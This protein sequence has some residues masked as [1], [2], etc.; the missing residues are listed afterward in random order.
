MY[1]LNK[2]VQITLALLSIALLVG[3]AF[4]FIQSSSRSNELDIL[5]MV[6][7]DE[8]TV[9]TDSAQSPASASSKIIF[10]DA[11]EEGYGIYMVN[12][13]G[14]ELTKVSDNSSYKGREA[15]PQWADDGNQIYFLGEGSERYTG[16][17]AINPDG[18]GVTKLFDW[19]DQEI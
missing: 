17:Y 10:V 4:L 6:P 8:T 18:S 9:V 5:P 13:D 14:T 16:L 19:G 15:K 7:G 1:L 3:A 12:P 11:G 2:S